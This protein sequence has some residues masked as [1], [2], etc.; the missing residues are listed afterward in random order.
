MGALAYKLG[1][2]GDIEAHSPQV[3]ATVSFK[4]AHAYLPASDPGADIDDIWFHSPLEGPPIEAQLLGDPLLGYPVIIAIP[5][6]FEMAL[7]AYAAQHALPPEGPV[8]LR[9]GEDIAGYLWLHGCL[10]EEG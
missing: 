8:A 3:G 2:A 4:G 7:T 10:A 5:E 9:P 1:P 6:D